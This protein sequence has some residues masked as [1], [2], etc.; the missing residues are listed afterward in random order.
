MSFSDAQNWNYGAK[1]GKNSA[2]FLCSVIHLVAALVQNEKVGVFLF[3]GFIDEDKRMI[4]C[5][6]H[7]S[8]GDGLIEKQLV[9]IEQ[10]IKMFSY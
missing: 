4:F 6:G 5:L 9:S 1:S 8:P 10:D 2:H 3:N 7:A